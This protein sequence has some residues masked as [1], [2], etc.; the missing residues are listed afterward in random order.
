MSEGEKNGEKE[1][2]N[3]CGRTF[4]TK[5]GDKKWREEEEVRDRRIKVESEAGEGGK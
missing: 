4:G 3:D 5:Q 1:E 2:N